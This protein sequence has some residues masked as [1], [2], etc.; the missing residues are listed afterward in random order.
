MEHMVSFVND[1]EILQQL[2]RLCCRANDSTNYSWKH[3]DLLNTDRSCRSDI[4]ILE[5]TPN[6]IRIGMAETNVLGTKTM[7]NLNQLKI[8]AKIMMP[9]IWK[10][11]SR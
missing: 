6:S 7:K 11:E 5:K 10:C 9:S 8:C 2:E 4:S 3:D 1:D